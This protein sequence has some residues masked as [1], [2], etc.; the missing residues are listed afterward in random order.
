MDNDDTVG[1]GH[2]L[3]ADVLP[4]SSGVHALCL[5]AG[6]GRLQ[7]WVGKSEILLVTEN[8]TVKIRQGP[9]S[10]YRSEQIQWIFRH[11]II[12]HPFA[13]LDASLEAPEVFS[14]VD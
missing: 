9:Y 13:D 10:S 5:P 12:G 14:A 3:L 7:S 4:S 11:A 1:R 2:D 6:G 8:L